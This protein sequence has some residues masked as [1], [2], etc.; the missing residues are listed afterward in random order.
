MSPMI[1]QYRRMS[2]ADPL[3][4][5]IDAVVHADAAADAAFAALPTLETARA[6]RTTITNRQRWDTFERDCYQ[7][8]Y[9]GSKLILSGVLALLAVI[10]PRRY[11]WQRNWRARS[12]PPFHLR[13]QPSTTYF[14]WCSAVAATATISS[15][16]AGHAITASSTSKSASLWS[17]QRTA[18]GTDSPTD[19]ER[20]GSAPASPRSCGG[21]SSSTPLHAQLDWPAA[22]TITD[23]VSS[24]DC[25]QRSL[26]AQGC[27]AKWDL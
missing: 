20:Y 1:R 2:D 21:A 4:A 27:P 19:I 12:I 8:R 9:C 3:A 11:P 6:N 17:I 25:P 10:D 23:Q 13:S 14:P 16:R 18:P 5:L 15:R 7:C 26:G 22:T 24:S